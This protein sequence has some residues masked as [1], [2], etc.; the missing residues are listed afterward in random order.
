MTS[1]PRGGGGVGPA[2]DLLEAVDILDELD[3]AVVR[4]RL[5]PVPRRRAR[6]ARRPALEREAQRPGA[7]VLAGV[8]RLRIGVGVGPRRQRVV[9]V[10]LRASPAERVSTR[11]ITSPLL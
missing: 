10:C 7:G 5:R 4:R 6:R 11:R 3:A 1:S 2:T 8:S 9:A